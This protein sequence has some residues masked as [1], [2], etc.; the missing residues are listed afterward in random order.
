MD[1]K[2]YL[3]DQIDSI[4]SLKEEL[5]GLAA[6]LLVYSD[7]FSDHRGGTEFIF[8]SDAVDRIADDY[9]DIAENLMECR[10]E[11]EKNYVKEERAEEK[12]ND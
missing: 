12:S 9:A 7:F 4:N 2:R 8:L 3:F 6:T 10:K 5:R 11:L 1:V